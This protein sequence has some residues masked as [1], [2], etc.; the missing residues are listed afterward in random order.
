MPIPE[1]EKAIPCK[2]VYQL[3]PATRAEPRNYKSRLVAKGFRQIYGIDYEDTYAPVVRHTALRILLSV[4]VNKKM[5]VHGMDVKNAFLKSELD[6]E[7]YMQ[8]PEVFVNQGNPNYVCKLEIAVF[9][10]KQSPRQWYNSIRPVLESVG[11]MNRR[12]A[13]EYFLG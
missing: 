4:A 1:G 12:V 7:V 5:H 6:H 3:K 9:G 10:L 2:W 13:V 11:F 8:Q